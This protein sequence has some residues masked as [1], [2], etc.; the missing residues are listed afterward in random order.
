M[1]C[2][3]GTILILLAVLCGC[4]RAPDTSH[5]SYFKAAQCREAGDY[6]AAA[7]Q[8]R[9][10]LAAR[11]DSPD[12]H[13]AIAS[14]YDENL[15][16]PLRAVYHYK[17]YLRLAPDSSEKEM[18]CA[19]LAAVEERYRNALNA[20]SGDGGVALDAS[21]PDD[22]TAAVA[23]RGDSPDLAVL[24]SQNQELKR[25]I[26]NQTR[27]LAELRAKLAQPGAAATATVRPAVRPT[28]P[29]RQALSNDVEYVVQ[30]GDTLGRIARRF[31]GAS[32]K[33]PIIMKANNLNG[34]SRL[35]IGQKL[36]IP[37]EKE[38]Q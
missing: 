12:G 34:S 6:E 37:A 3:A 5:P 14:L 8:L 32:S 4:E 30:A 25:L 31:Y 36:R 22:G 29:R 17:E 1:R 15:D 38:G 7:G 16:D 18:A 2:V 24:R 23:A 10:F 11:P 27:E 26:F 13:L 33:F 21:V 28:M 35:R 20:A 9:R 19:W